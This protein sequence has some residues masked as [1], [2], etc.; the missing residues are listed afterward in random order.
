MLFNPVAT[1]EK[2]S[3]S[4]FEKSEIEI[5]TDDE[6]KRLEEACVSKYSNGEYIYKTGNGFILMLYTGIRTAEA[7]ALKWSDIDF[8]ERY[9]YI[10]ILLW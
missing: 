10:R 2:P 9:M 6:I 3:S 5:L 8:K 1:V 7:L 4:K